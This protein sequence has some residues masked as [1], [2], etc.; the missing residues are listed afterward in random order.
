MM[1][2]GHDVRL[3]GWPRLWSKFTDVNL[4][5]EQVPPRGTKIKI[6]PISIFKS[7][8][9]RRLVAKERLIF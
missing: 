3:S 7:T 6:T 4:W 2:V 5:E 1:E 9:L 8:L